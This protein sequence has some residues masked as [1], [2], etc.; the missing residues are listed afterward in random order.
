MSVEPVVQSNAMGAS[1]HSHNNYCSEPSFTIYVHVTYGA[2]LSYIVDGAPC[3]GTL[4]LPVGEAG[5]LPSNRRNSFRRIR[6]LAVRRMD[7]RRMEAL[8]F[9]PCYLLTYVTYSSF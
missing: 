8:P 4:H 6:R 7:V 3:T 2:L 5:G 1:C 9:I